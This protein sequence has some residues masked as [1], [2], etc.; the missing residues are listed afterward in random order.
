MKLNTRNSR[1]HKNSLVFCGTRSIKLSRCLYRNFS[2][3]NKNFSKNDVEKFNGKLSHLTLILPQ[4]KPYLVANFKWMATWRSPGKRGMPPEVLKDLLYWKT[5]LSLLN[6]T[7]LIPDR[8]I[9]NVGWV[10]DASSSY[11]IGIIIG[12]HWSQFAWRPNW[13][14]PPG[15]PKRTIAWAE[16][17]AVRLGLLMLACIMPT[18]GYSF[19][20]LTD[21]T[22]TEGAARN[23][24]SKDFWVN[25][26][27]K[28]IQTLLIEMDCDINLVRVISADNNADNL[29]RG[30]GTSKATHHMIAINVPLDLTP[31]LYQ[32]F[33]TP[34]S[35]D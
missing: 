23:R 19:S 18:P 1:Q 35:Y 7:R 22:T 16:T 32:V 28:L 11:G 31:Y 4:L 8:T 29:S 25:E 12:K 14:N 34:I 15:Q 17:V 20:C 26:E 10:G 24:K 27:W 2:N 9:R 30:L 21:N 33:P 3:D 13:S 6:P 5:V